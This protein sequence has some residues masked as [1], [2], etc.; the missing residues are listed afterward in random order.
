[1]P[2]SAHALTAKDE[3]QST[4]LYTC[5]TVK[6]GVSLLAGSMSTDKM[7]LPFLCVQCTGAHTQ[8][9]GWLCKCALF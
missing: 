7:R 8:S 9:Y 5:N 2:V 6:P 4:C 1:M 3:E